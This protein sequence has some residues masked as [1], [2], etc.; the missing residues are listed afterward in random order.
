MKRSTKLAALVLAPLS[1]LAALIWRPSR[2]V[3]LPEMK[4]RAALHL[5]F[6][7]SRTRVAAFLRAQHI[8]MQ[9]EVGAN[10]FSKNA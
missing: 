2:R 3:T 5:D 1:I 9:T 6:G 10:R 4:S 8:P 7:S